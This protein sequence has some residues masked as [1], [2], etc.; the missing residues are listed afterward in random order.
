MSTNVTWMYC[1]SV[2]T[3][4]LAKALTSSADVVIYDLEDSVLGHQKDRGRE[5]LRGFLS[6]LPR[7]TD[8]PEIH[9][10]INGFG[11]PW[12]E[13]DLNM[14]ASVDMFDAVRIPKVES[15]VEIEKV[16]S[17]LND[18]DL[19]ALVESAK[20][21]TALHEICA[22]EDVAGVSLGDAD[23]RA[24]LRLSGEQVLDHIRM[25]LVLALA[26]HGKPSPVGSVYLDLADPRGLLEHTRHLKSMGFLGRTALHPK[27]LAVI[28][29]GFRPSEMEISQ[30]RAILD[31]TEKAEADLQSGAFTLPNGQFV[32]VPIIQ[33]ARDTLLLAEST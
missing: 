32:D 3:D 8:R 21:V 23:L 11:T 31:A 27:Q 33:Q 26:T 5:I 14:L 6:S 16:R 20:G 24:Q 25:Q 29:E 22:H 4:L 18:C 30:A 12:V 13:A 7:L 2:R 9:I 15:S 28:R 10:R 1:P 17:I 19:H